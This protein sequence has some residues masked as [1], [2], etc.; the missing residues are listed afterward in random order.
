MLS[1]PQKGLKCFVA[2]V[3]SN[4]KVMKYERQRFPQ[5]HTAHSTHIN[6]HLTIS[7]PS[8]CPLYTVSLKSTCLDKQTMLEDRCILLVKMVWFPQ[9]HVFFRFCNECSMCTRRLIL[10]RAMFRNKQLSRILLLYKNHHN[11]IFSKG[12]CSR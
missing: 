7:Q 8:C 4:E 3:F 1:N 10:Q 12:T 9:T 11:S 2:E 5:Q 6:V